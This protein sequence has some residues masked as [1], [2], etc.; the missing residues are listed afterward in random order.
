MLKKI[1]TAILIVVF[2]IC[3][4]AMNVKPI[5]SGYSN[6][7]EVYQARGSI[8][9]PI[10]NC[11]ALE[12]LFM[13]KVAGEGCKVDAS[14]F[15][16][17]EFLYEYDAKIVF[18]EQTGGITS[19]YAYSPKVKYLENIGGKVVNLQVAVRGEQITLGA[20]IIYGSF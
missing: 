20:P 9:S 13:R 3:V 11:T 5:F 6:N 1:F 4:Y 8:L 12:M 15:D 19:Y 10:T 14:E 16:L 7:F 18:I 17:A 2:F